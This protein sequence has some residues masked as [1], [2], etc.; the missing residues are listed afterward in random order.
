MSVFRLWAQNPLQLSAMWLRN[1]SLAAGMW[2]D[3]NNRPLL[4]ELVDGDVAEM[5]LFYFF[6]Q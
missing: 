2:T 3:E 1:F 6:G 4:C 5:D